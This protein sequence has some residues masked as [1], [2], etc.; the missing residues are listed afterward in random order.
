MSGDLEE[1]VALA[2]MNSD[3]VAGGLPELASRDDVPDSDGYL[4]NAM[5]VIPLVMEDA[6]KVAEALS[7]DASLDGAEAHGAYLAAA[8]IRACAK[9]VG[10]E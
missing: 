9:E 5:A 2:I 6:A 4:R 7:E 3:R 8:A 10:Q 1:R